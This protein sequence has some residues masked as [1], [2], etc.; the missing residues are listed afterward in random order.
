MLAANHAG[1]GTFP[2]PG[3]ALLVA[4]GHGLFLDS[5]L[6]DCKYRIIVGTLGRG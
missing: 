4:L 1:L 5:T 3:L 2:R 6:A